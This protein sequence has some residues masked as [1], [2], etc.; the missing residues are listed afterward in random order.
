MKILLTP[1]VILYVEM[2]NTMRWFSFKIIVFYNISLS[3]SPVAE[4]ETLIEK[5]RIQSEN[6]SSYNG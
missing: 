2:T 5:V 6:V 3:A 1:G 4:R